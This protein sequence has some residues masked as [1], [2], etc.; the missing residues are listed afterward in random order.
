MFL[1][2]ACLFKMA[3]ELFEFS[4]FHF[5]TQFPFNKCSLFIPS[6]WALLI[7][8]LIEKQN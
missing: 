8:N 6:L 4:Q 3:W 1:M 2:A 5:S 7:Y